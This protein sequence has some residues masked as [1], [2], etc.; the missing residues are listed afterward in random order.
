MEKCDLMQIYLGWHKLM[1]WSVYDFSLIEKRSQ[2][3]DR[4]NKDSFEANRHL[5]KPPML[6][7]VAWSQTT[8]CYTIS[9]F[10]SK[11][12]HW[13]WTG[14]KN[15]HTTSSIEV[16]NLDFIRKPKM[17]LYLAAPLWRVKSSSWLNGRLVHIVTSEKT[18]SPSLHLWCNVGNVG[19]SIYLGNKDEKN[20]D[21]SENRC[22][23]HN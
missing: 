4:M 5:K 14:K 11:P 18:A 21:T 20:C 23:T 3:V 9:F 12:T 22:F 15:N 19:S 1:R 17:C 13:Q 6:N 8:T 2:N 10:G 16:F 7:L